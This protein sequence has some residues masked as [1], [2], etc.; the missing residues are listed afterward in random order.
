MIST[1]QAL[2]RLFA[3]VAPL[4]TEEVGLAEAAGRV[5]AADVVAARA[6]PPFAASAMDGYALRRAD[7][8]EG[9]RLRVIGAAPAGRAFAGRVGPGEAVRIFTGAPVPAG[10][11]HVVL[12]EACAPDRDGV[13]IVAAP[14]DNANI[15]PAG[16][17]FAP[18]DRI[19]APR[20]L[21]RNDLALAAGMDAPRLTVRR[22]PEVAIV[23]TG[24]ELVLP[25]TP[26]R[27]DQIVASNGFGLKA[28]VELHGARARLLPVAGDRAESLV[29]VLDLAQGADLVVT[30]GGASVGEHDLVARVAQGIG[31][32]LAFHRVALRPGKP[33][34]AGRLRGAALVG[35]PGNPVSAMV[36]AELFVVP[37]LRVLLGLPAAP[38]P[39]VPVILAAPVPANGPREHYMRAR[40]QGEVLTPFERQDSALLSLLSRANALL[41]RPPHAPAAS[42]GAA[43]EAVLLSR[44]SCAD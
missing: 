19:C 21:S 16:A 20:R 3:L 26:R 34:I 9:A 37:M 33:L 2:E 22:R 35:L 25:G 5:L 1:A 41:V 39:R 30:V 8:A 10:A 12:Q 14:S 18:G 13:R 4:D 31:M 43:A 15:R 24:D 11:D 7:L 6:Q 36:C 29:A 40:L 28:L 17:D 32:D 38:P 42:A 23:M 27:D 44:M